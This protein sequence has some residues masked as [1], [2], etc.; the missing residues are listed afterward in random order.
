MTRRALL[1][2]AGAASG[3]GYHVSGRAD[4]VPKSIH[5]IAVPAFS[6]ITTRYTLNDRLPEAISREFIARTRFQVVNREDEADAVLRGSVTNFYLSPIVATGSTTVVLVGVTMNLRLLDRAKGTV[7]FQRPSLDVRQRY[8]IAAPRSD[9]NSRQL[10]R[11]VYFDESEAA[12][13]RLSREVA[14]MVV[15]A[16]LENF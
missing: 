12:L 1:L 2:A 16:I 15:S 8:E 13:E 6:N 10:D 7:L 11:N 9:P 4:L 3:C 14:R 5:T